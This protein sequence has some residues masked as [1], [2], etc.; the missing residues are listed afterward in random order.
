MCGDLPGRKAWD[1]GE[2]LG[3]KEG[4][5]SNK[6]SSCKTR[7]WKVG[8]EEFNR[9]LS[10]ELERGLTVGDSAGEGRR[11]LVWRDQGWLEGWLRV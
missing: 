7:S 2:N 3:S 5:R 9:D 1:L 11:M 6:R 10:L 8:E 4:S